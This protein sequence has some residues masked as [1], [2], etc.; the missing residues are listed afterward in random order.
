MSR[1]S[2]PMLLLGVLTTALCAAV[3]LA[4]SCPGDCDGS[5]DVTINEL[6]VM[7]NIALGSAPVS[8]CPTGDSDGDGAIAINEIIAAVNAAL[9]GC[10]GVASTPTPTPMSTTH[11]VRI[12]SDGFSFSPSSLTIQVGDTVEWSWS[13][14]GHT[15]TS[16]SQCSAD[17]QFCSPATPIAPAHRRQTR[18][19]PIATRSAQRGRSPISAY[20]TASSGW[21]VRSSSNLPPRHR[22]GSLT[23]RPWVCRLR[24]L[25]DI[26][27][28]VARAPWPGPR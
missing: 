22:A 2:I 6:I 4:Q 11:M 14:S 3:A 27:H 9:N 26:N 21:S 25:L 24:A 20:R 18:A 10:T 13:S 12:G 15:V 1:H 19:Q 16:G 8:D 23:F 28:L 5:G 7:V 17:G